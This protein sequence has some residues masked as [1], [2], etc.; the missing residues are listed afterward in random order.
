VVCTVQAVAVPPA[1]ADHGDSQAG[2]ALSPAVSGGGA[3]P[4][5]IAVIG[6][7]A[8]VVGLAALVRVRGRRDRATPV[9]AVAGPA[10]AELA[11]MHAPPA[12][13]PVRVSYKRR[14]AAARRM[15]TCQVRWSTDGWFYAVTTGR[16]GRAH[17]IASS[18]PV[19]WHEP[20]PPEAT[21]ATQWALERLVKDLLERDWRPLRQKSID[22]DERRWYARRFRRPTKEELTEAREAA[23]A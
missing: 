18:P 17:M 8:P 20:G 9:L 14:A 2:T 11:P 10:P 7:A 15:P 5:L 1:L 13:E 4:A 21:P 16:D 3:L 6:V 12:A 23:G 22:F 19:A